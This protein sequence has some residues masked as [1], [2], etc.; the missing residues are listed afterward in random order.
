MFR[1]TCFFCVAAFDW[2]LKQFHK[3]PGSSKRAKI[4]P[5]SAHWTDPEYPKKTSSKCN[6]EIANRLAYSMCSFANRPPSSF[7]AGLEVMVL[8]TSAWLEGT[9]GKTNAPDDSS[10]FPYQC[11]DGLGLFILIADI[12]SPEVLHR[13][14][15]QRHVPKM[16]ALLAKEMPSLSCLPGSLPSSSTPASTPALYCCLTTWCHTQVQSGARFLSFLVLTIWHCCLPKKPPQRQTFYVSR[17]SRYA[18]QNGAWNLRLNFVSGMFQSTSL[19]HHATLPPPPKKHTQTLPTSVFFFSCN[20]NILNTFT[21]VLGGSTFN[22]ETLLF[23]HPF[24]P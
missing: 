15:S 12:L 9:C 7:K 2:Y 19:Q 24:L 1:N 18:H 10:H 3:I 6:L 20:L 11:V 8:G 23:F 17:R 22:G 4:W 16:A 21:F 13:D 5:F 14:L